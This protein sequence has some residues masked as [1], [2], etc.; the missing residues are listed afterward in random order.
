MDTMTAMIAVDETDDMETMRQ[1][2]QVLINTGL[3]WTLQGRVGR[4]AVDCIERG[5]CALGVESRRDYW[6][7]RI[8][9]RFEV[10]PGTMG[11][12]E[13]VQANGYEVAS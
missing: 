9:S 3:A 10:E 12:I 5:A 11:S 13:Y 1:A 7:N 6:G 2:L 4:A 8:P